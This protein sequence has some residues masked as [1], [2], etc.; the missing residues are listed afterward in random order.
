MGVYW[1]FVNTEAYPFNNKKMR[2]A[3]AYAIHRKAITDHI[4]QEGEMPAL[5]VLPKLLNVSNRPYFPDHEVNEA[6]KLFQEAL[7]EM[8]ITK[9][10]LPPITLSYNS[11]EYHQRT[12]Q[13]VQEQWLKAF[14][15]KVKLEQ[16]EWKVHYQKL[17]SGNFQIGGMGWH[18]WLRD[19]IY[20]MQTFRY[21]ADGINMSRWEHP[22]Y[23]SLLEA[24]EHE[25]NKEKRRTLFYEAEKLLMDEMP[26]IPVYF[27]SICYAKKDGLKNVYISELNQLDFKWAEYKR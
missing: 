14:G 5:G 18:S 1:Y 22:L 2:K 4:L 21:R 16:E 20:I 26:V 24:T 10:Q 8:G 3:F 27:T 6:R 9:E 13:I 12:A 17:I 19:P 25:V 23:Q 7:D 15:I 11:S